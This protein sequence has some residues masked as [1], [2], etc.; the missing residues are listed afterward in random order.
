MSRPT[1]TLVPQVEPRELWEE[2]SVERPKSYELTAADGA[3]RQLTKAVNYSRY[4]II[5]TK[6]D[7]SISG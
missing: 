3:T 6:A 5:K 2:M 4:N 7:Y 1:R